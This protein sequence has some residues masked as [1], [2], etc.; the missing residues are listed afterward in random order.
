MDFLHLGCWFLSFQFFEEVIFF[1]QKFKLFEVGLFVLFVY[2]VDKVVLVEVVLILFSKL[3]GYFLDVLWPHFGLKLLKLLFVVFQFLL[4][5]VNSGLF[6]WYLTVWR[7]LC[8]FCQLR[9]KLLIENICQVKIWLV[10]TVSWRFICI[11]LLIQSLEN[12]I[13]LFNHLGLLVHVL[14]FFSVGEFSLLSYL[15]VNFSGLLKLLIILDRSGLK[16][17]LKLGVDSFE[18]GD[19]LAVSVDLLFDGFILLKV[20]IDLVSV[21]KNFSLKILE[22]S[23]DGLLIRQEAGFPCR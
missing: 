21:T 22:L 12:D 6:G 17:R 13:V 5:F 8:W 15:N 18:S 11:Q 2:F 3:S 14:H 1:L 16:W 20:G 10:I 19:L 4:Y 7:F 9:L 23:F